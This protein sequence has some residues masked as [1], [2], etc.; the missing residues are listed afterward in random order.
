M[1]MQLSPEQ[2]RKL[3][4][5]EFWRPEVGRQVTVTVSGFRYEEQRFKSEHGDP[6]PTLVM[7]VLALDG[8]IQRPAKKWTSTNKTVNKA[9]LAAMDQANERGQDYVKVAVLRT[10]ERTYS[11]VDVHTIEQATGQRIDVAPTMR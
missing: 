8:Y 10:D 11:V 9:L 7:D 5:S 4:E 6:R 3:T 1:V 2:R